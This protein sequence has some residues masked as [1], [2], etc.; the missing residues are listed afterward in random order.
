MTGTSQSPPGGLGRPPPAPGLP[1]RR[2]LINEVHVRPFARVTA[3]Q[4]ASHLA[5]ATCEAVAAR[6]EAR[7]DR[8]SRASQLPRT[9]IDI[10]LEAQ[11]GGLLRALA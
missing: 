5:M 11:N 10:A 2:A 6:L 3:R 7:S 1:L 8:V 9:R 4:R